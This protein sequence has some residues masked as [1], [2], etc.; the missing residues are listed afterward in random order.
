MGFFRLTQFIVFIFS[1]HAENKSYEIKVKKIIIRGE[2]SEII[3]CTIN[4]FECL[5]TEM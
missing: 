5:Y 2:I 3:F 1:K 4:V